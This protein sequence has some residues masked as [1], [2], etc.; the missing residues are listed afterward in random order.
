MCYYLLTK[1]NGDNMQKIET[2]TI[3][4]TARNFIDV[5]KQVEFS[6][7]SA[8]ARKIEVLKIAC[9]PENTLSSVVLTSLH[10]AVRKCKK[11]EKIDFFIFGE[12]FFS[13]DA[14]TDYLLGRAEYAK[15]YED[16]EKQNRNIVIVYISPKK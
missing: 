1:L 11:M 10:R 2:V 6:V 8:T 16:F 14:A 3:D 15:D 13:G 9:D 5:L 4:K 7:A 12:N